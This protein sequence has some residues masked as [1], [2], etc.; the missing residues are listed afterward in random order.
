MN[1]NMAISPCSEN[2]KIIAESIYAIKAWRVW[3]H[4]GL[5]DM[6]NQFRRSRLGTL[7]VL[8]NLTLM[9]GGIG[10]VYGHLFHQDL[11][12]F[13]PLLI[14]GIVIWNFIAT[15]IVQG[16]NT[17]IVSEGYVKQFSFPKQIYIL[18]FFLAALL[19]LL[20]GFAVFFVVALSQHVPFALGTFWAL[21]GLILLILISIAHIIIFAYW[22]VKVRDLAPALSGIFLILFYIT[23]IVFTPKILGEHNLAFIYQFNPLYYLIEVVRYP[24]INGSMAQP[25]IYYATL[26]Y[27]V[28]VW[29][30]AVLTLFKCDR[31]VAYWL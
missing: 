29:S 10:Y 5:Q 3:S 27:G 30:V 22:G 14:A 31:K 28:L 4:M 17:F 21:I 1:N 18:R 11:S 15:T 12:V 23:P 26:S 7:W 25:E 8:I 19:N 24:L 13:F 2:K 6:R 20:I 9:A 16:C